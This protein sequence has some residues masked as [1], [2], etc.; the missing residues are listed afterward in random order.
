MPRSN[1]SSGNAA[2]KVSPNLKP[3]WQQKIGGLITSPTIAEGMV[4]LAK[5]DLHEVCAF[6]AATGEP[7][8]RY[9]AGGRVDSAPSWYK[10]YLIFGSA[11]GWV[12]ALRA[13]DGALAWRTRLGGAV[14]SS[15]TVTKSVI[16]R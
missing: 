8:W 2:A 16:C 14:N 9:T 11:D 5:P 1:A 13:A 3:L 12:Y 15:P 6:D 7:R 10:G 4:F